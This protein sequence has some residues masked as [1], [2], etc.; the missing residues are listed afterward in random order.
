[1][2]HSVADLRLNTATAP[3]NGGNQNLKVVGNSVIETSFWRVIESLGTEK[4]AQICCVVQVL[5][6]VEILATVG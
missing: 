6:C 1:M 2:T 4:T 5:V 3:S